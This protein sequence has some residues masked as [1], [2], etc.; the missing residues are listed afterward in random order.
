MGVRCTFHPSYCGDLFTGHFEVIYY[1][2]LF[3]GHFEVTG[4]I[5]PTLRGRV[6]IVH[7]I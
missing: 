2:D 4:E 6:Y 1:G 3:T 5:H 7:P